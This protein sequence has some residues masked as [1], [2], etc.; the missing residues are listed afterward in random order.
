MKSRDEIREV[1]FIQMIKQYSF[2]L[3]ITPSE[4][5]LYVIARFYVQVQAFLQ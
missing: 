2:F 1:E 3:N 5:Q 4:D